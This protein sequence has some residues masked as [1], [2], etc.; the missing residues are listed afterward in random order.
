MSLGGD[1]E[2]EGDGMGRDPT[3]GVGSLS[4]RV[5]AQP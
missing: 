3:G 5:G 1:T 4:Q 2:E